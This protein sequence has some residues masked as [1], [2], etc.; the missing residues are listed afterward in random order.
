MKRSIIVLCLSLAAAGACRAQEGIMGAPGDSV[1]V[2][3][4]TER[5]ASDSVI[6]IRIHAAGL[7]RR[8]VEEIILRGDQ[9]YSAPD[10]ALGIRFFSLDDFPGEMFF[11]KM[12][13]SGAYI[14]IGASYRRGVYHSRGE[15]WSL[16][17]D[18]D[19][20][21]AHQSAWSASV[22][23]DLEIPLK[24]Y[25]GWNAF[26][27]VTAL[28]G[29]GKTDSTREYDAVPYTG[30]DV[31]AHARYDEIGFGLDLRIEKEFH[32]G[33][34]TFAVGVI[35]PVLYF[36]KTHEVVDVRYTY[37]YSGAT[38]IFRADDKRPWQF[39]Y[40]NPLSGRI[41][42]QLKYLFY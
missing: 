20:G 21:F 25:K 32:V 34:S 15:R 19:T 36:E 17:S 24:R 10:M 30:M 28:Y 38:T 33:T 40:N 22:N 41:G 27:A 14:G 37:Y 42:L 7:A 6:V 5:T 13:P 39:G 9:P 2:T 29:H 16:Y 8:T 31:D 26:A 35:N 3:V 1:T 23:L 4:A 18:R 12:M 11:Q